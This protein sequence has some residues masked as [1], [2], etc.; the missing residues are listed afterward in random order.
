[1]ERGGSRQRRSPV[2]ARPNTA[3]RHLQQQRAN[4]ADKKVVIPNYFGVEAFFVLACLTV[5]LLILP[6]VLPPLP[7]PPSLL[8]FVPV[9]QFVLQQAPKELCCLDSFCHCNTIRLS[10]M[11]TQC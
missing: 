7:P 10:Q 2:L 11:A 8:L 4:A 9:P 5:S 1:M 6:L 3:K